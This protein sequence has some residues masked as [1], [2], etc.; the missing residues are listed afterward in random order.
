MNIIDLAFKM[1]VHIYYLVK[2]VV[3]L[4]TALSLWC[5]NSLFGYLTYTTYGLDDLGALTR[6]PPCGPR[7]VHQL[8]NSG[9]LRYGCFRTFKKENAFQ[10][11][12]DK[13]I[14]L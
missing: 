11:I 12:L 1:D 10:V 2:K 3:T 5:K 4:T 7:G 14:F 6:R 13:L 8:D 9:T